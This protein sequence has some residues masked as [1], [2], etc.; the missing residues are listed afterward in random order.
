MKKA[1]KFLYNIKIDVNRDDEMQKIINILL[2]INLLFLL[3]LTG[4]IENKTVCETNVDNDSYSMNNLF[5][6]INELKTNNDFQTDSNN[7][8]PARRNFCFGT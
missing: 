4:C 5:D 6:K 7:F 2:S 3:L 1:F 8:S